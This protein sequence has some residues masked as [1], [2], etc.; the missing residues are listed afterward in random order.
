LWSKVICPECDGKGA[1]AKREILGVIDPRST[2]DG[3]TRNSVAINTLWRER[4]NR[5]DVRDISQKIISV[6][7][8]DEA[9]QWEGWGTGLKPAFN[10]HHSC[11]ETDK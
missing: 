11:P 9:K 10:P 2:Y 5:T 8:T 1:G 6:P 7:A 4:E 3:G